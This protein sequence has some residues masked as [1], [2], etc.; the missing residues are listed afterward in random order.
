L[1]IEKG[2]R[3]GAVLRFLPPLVI[4]EVQINFVIETIEKAIKI[5]VEAQ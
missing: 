5:A 4:S 1:I 3:Q 2:G